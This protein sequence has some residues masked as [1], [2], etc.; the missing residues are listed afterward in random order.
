MKLCDYE[1]GE[2]LAKSL[3][4][5]DCHVDQYA[6]WCSLDHITPRIPFSLL[7]ETGV[8]GNGVFSF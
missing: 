2:T 8:C 5:S 6:K 1:N 3:R 7:T 4:E